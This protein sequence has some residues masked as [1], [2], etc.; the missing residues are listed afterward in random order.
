MEIYPL[1]LLRCSTSVATGVAGLPHLS[2]AATPG[3]G[4]QDAGFVPE[5]RRQPLDLPGA[6]CRRACLAWWLR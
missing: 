1:P 2:R 6:S 3:S 4:V 5:A